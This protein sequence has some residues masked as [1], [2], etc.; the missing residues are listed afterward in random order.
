MATAYGGTPVLASA[1]KDEPTLA[2]RS[3]RR[4]Y[5]T[6][7]YKTSDCKTSDHAAKKI[8]NDPGAEDSSEPTIGASPAY[9]QGKRV[10]GPGLLANV[11]RYESTSRA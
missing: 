8:A 5:E 3:P 1:R 10:R 9:A 4:L 7:D 2:W 6:S 11:R